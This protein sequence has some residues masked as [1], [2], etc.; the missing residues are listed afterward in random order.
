MLAYRFDKIDTIHV[1][2]NQGRDCIEKCKK[3]L[4]AREKELA[5]TLSEKNKM[6]DEDKTE[7]VKKLEEAI[8]NLRQTIK[9]SEIFRKSARSYM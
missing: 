7:R 3:V 1:A 8:E 2:G 5:C 9:R 4:A 6:S